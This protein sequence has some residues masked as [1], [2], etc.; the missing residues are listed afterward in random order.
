MKQP[1]LMNEF[2]FKLLYITVKPKHMLC[3]NINAVKLC[4]KRISMREWVREVRSVSKIYG[5]CELQ[6]V[7]KRLARLIN[8]NNFFSRLL[9]L[10]YHVHKFHFYPTFCVCTERESCYTFLRMYCIQTL[11]V[12]TKICKLRHANLQ[13]L[14]A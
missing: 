9:P 5:L 12:V 7:W 13:R 4:H 6:L 8:S 2:N 10:N 14:I 3:T 11:S 1:F